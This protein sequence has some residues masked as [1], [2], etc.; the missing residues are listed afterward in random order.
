MARDGLYT[1]WPL[2][3]MARNG[4]YTVWPPDLQS[5]ARPGARDSVV[6]IRCHTLRYLGLSRD[7]DQFAP[8]R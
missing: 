4:L 7:S 5:R 2:Q 3:R 6:S 8:A 1:E